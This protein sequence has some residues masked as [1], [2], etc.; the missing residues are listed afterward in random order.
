MYKQ[1]IAPKNIFKIILVVIAIWLVSETLDATFSSYVEPDYYDEYELEHEVIAANVDDE[2]ELVEVDNDEAVSNGP[3]YNEVEVV[4]EEPAADEAVDDELVDDEVNVDG[5]EVDE[6]EVDGDEVDEDEV[7]GDEI[8][9]DEVDEDEVDEDEVDE[10]EV[11]EDEVDEDEVDEDEV[12]EDE[13]DEDE[14]DEDEDDEDEDDEDDED[15]DDEDEDDEV[16]LDDDSER[17][18]SDF[19]AD[20]ALASAIVD[21]LN[22]LGNEVD[23]YTYITPDY[24]ATITDLTHNRLLHGELTSLAGIERLV[25]LQ[26]LRADTTA[27]QEVGVSNILPL[28]NLTSLETVALWH[29]D[30]SDLSPLGG[31]T[32]LTD[33]TLSNNNIS[34]ISPLSGL[35][36]LERLALTMNQITDFR[37]LAALTNLESLGVNFQSIDLGEVAVGQ[38]VPLA[39][40]YPDGTRV[41]IAATF[42]TVGDGTIM[43]DS[44]DL[45]TGIANWNSSFVL[46]NLEV[47]NFTG[48]IRADLVEASADSDL[49]S[50]SGGE[51]NNVVAT[52]PTTTATQPPTTATQPTTTDNTQST[53]LSPGGGAVGGGGNSNTTLPQPVL[54]LP[55]PVLPQ[56]GAAIAT[57]SLTLFG[58]AFISIG[59]LVARRRKK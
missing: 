27:T 31:L 11:D 37:P 33:L 44:L 29:H 22:S 5:D 55:R 3:V 12:D 20:E 48:N 52:Q 50:D 42:G 39:V 15:E 10:D 1:F 24:L 34:D 19:F 18:V 36:G 54:P 26:H 59:A 6:D 13:D 32:N 43:W 57:G 45:E 58:A 51:T 4:D 38:P 21:N 49:E 46:G 17:P 23:M 35:V 40:Y 30:V 14:D 2:E 41:A 53:Q 56:T 47:T 25:N 8:D 9:E 7:D 28:A 16:D